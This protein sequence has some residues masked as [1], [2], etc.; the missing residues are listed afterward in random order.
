MGKFCDTRGN[1]S[2]GRNKVRIKLPRLSE[3]QD[4]GLQRL[5]K[6]S[7]ADLKVT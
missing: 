4:F 3:P 6:F 5:I 7:L 2:S 1:N